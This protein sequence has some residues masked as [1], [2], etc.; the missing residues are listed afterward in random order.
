ME[1]VNKKKQW[2]ETHRND[3]NY[4]EC[5]KEARR[6]YYYANIEKERQRALNRYYA[7]KGVT[8]PT[9]PAPTALDEFLIHPPPE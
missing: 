9:P 2:Y 7:L 1:A 5:M 6:K 3:T 4:K 8:A